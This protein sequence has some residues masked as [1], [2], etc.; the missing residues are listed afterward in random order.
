MTAMVPT[1]PDRR[2]EALVFALVWLPYALLV[3]RFWFLCDDAF[4]SFRF[5]SHWAAGEG[6]R[7]NP[8]QHVPVE[9][10]SNFLWVALSAL[11]ERLGPG[12]PAAMP[13]ASFALGSVLLAAV[14]RVLLRRLELPLHVAARATLSLGCSPPFALWSNVERALLSDSIDAI[15]QSNN[16]VFRSR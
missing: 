15:R 3:R 7:F 2:R 16:Q 10:Y 5:A 9:G 1:R 14:F 6:V 4:I 8:G 12:A 11:F 13:W